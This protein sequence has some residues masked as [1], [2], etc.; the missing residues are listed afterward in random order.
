MTTLGKHAR[1]ESVAKEHPAE[2]KAKVFRSE[3]DWTIHYKN[4][5]FHVE[6]KRM[7]MHSDWFAN[8]DEKDSDK[9]ATIE[10]DLGSVGAFGDLLKMLDSPF[11]V[12]Q[13]TWT[14]TEIIDYYHMAAYLG[15]SSIFRLLESNLILCNWDEVM[16]EDF[17]RVADFAIF[18]KTQK[19]ASMYA[20]VL[21]G[22]AGCLLKHNHDPRT[23]AASDAK[24]WDRLRQEPGLGVGME[25]LKK[26]PI[27]L[28]QHLLIVVTKLASGGN[29]TGN[30]FATG[31][32]ASDILR[33]IGMLPTA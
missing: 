10:T 18:L 24:G 33:W 16:K 9:T 21:R 15:V 26:L 8:L 22:M 31:I 14:T 11:S 30:V 2:K 7:A 3:W 29:T 12:D 1:D 17:G 32:D 13:F 25:R 19:L 27:E 6:R 28:I 5:A 4:Q 20:A 23:A